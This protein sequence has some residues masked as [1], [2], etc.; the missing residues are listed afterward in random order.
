[1]RMRITRYTRY[2]TIR[3]RKRMSMEE[4]QQNIK[5]KIVDEIFTAR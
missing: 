1:M 5:F 4:L 3:N 2:K